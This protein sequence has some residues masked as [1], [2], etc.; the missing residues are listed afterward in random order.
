MDKDR[1]AGAGKQ[2]KG[3]AKD[4]AGKVMGDKKMQAEGKMDKA[5]GKLQKEVGKGKDAIRD[6]SRHWSC[7]RPAVT[8]VVAGSFAF[9]ANPCWRSSTTGGI[10]AAEPF[11]R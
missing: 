7:S 9:G 4:A 6:A 10:T 1:I 3:A 5:E 11:T 8:L 2:A